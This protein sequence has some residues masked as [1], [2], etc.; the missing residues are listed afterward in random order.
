MN[1][2]C[3]PPP[4]RRHLMQQMG[5]AA[6][7]A[8]LLPLIPLA[9]ADQLRTLRA[10]VLRVGT[11]F[12]NPPFEFISGGKRVGFEVDL[13]EEIARRLDLHSEF[14]NT[15]WEV[16]LRHMEENRYD[17]IVGG[18]TITPDRQRLLAWSV[19]YLTT[20]L[21]LLVDLRRSP[22]NMTL[23]D[24]KGGTVGVQ[25]ATT[26]YD[27]A[28]AM[29]RAGQIGN[30]KVYPFAKI[31]DAIKDLSSGRVDA[32]MKVYPVAAWFVRKTPGLRILAQVPDAPQPL[33]IGFN[34]NN[35]SLVAAVDHALT[36]MQQDKI[37]QALAQRWGVT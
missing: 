22:A 8:L 2:A 13:M 17:C 30:V 23:A 37:Y 25:A 35:P 18:I 27:V 24:L 29:Q 7:A 12:V 11:Y 36:K 19:P 31:G 26:D 15:R 14:V 10:G 16:I 34:R 4:S 5:A 9:R 1:A 21:S 6:S 32:V 20:T 33:G 3:K 28:V